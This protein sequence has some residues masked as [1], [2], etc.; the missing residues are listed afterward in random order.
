M[1]ARFWGLTA[2]VSGVIG[3]D[4]WTGRALSDTEPA[5][6]FGLGAFAV[7]T[8]RVS[9]RPGWAASQAAIFA[10]LWSR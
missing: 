2:M 3:V 5:V 8:V 10:S 7:V 6:Y 1:F 9:T 4:V